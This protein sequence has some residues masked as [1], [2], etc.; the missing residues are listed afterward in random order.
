MQ[1]SFA[2]T[3]NQYEFVQQLG[4]DRLFGIGG[5]VA[6]HRLRGGFFA[7]FLNQPV[8]GLIGS[9]GF[10]RPTG[11]GHFLTVFGQ[12]NGC[13]RDRS[14]TAGQRAQGVQ[15]EFVDPHAAGRQLHR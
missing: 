11:C 7:M 4:I 14:D 6:D 10:A 1:P 12:E 13:D 9:H 5:R 2:A 3:L 8:Q 15:C